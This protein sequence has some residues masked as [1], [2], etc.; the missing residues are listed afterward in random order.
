M[1]NLSEGF[2]LLVPVMI[3]TSPF[4]FASNFMAN[5]NADVNVWWGNKSK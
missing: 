5:T 2:G 4:G 1:A 3:S